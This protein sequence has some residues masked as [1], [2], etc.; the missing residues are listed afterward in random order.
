MAKDIY[1]PN[2]VSD[3]DMYIQ[4]T[5]S[6]YGISHD[7]FRKQLWSES[8]FKADAKSPTGPLG[9]AQFTEATGKAYGLLTPEDRMDPFKSIDAAGRHV[10]DLVQQYGGDELKAMLAYNQGSGK[11]GKPQLDAYDNGDYSK[12]STEGLKYMMTLKDV[13]KSDRKEAL[14]AFGGLTPKSNPTEAESLF[15]S[16]SEAKSSVELGDFAQASGLSLV[17]KEVAQAN[18]DYTKDYYNWHGET[19]EQVR[20]RSTFFKTEESILRESRNSVLGLAYRAGI[21]D[22]AWSVFTDSFVPTR[23]NTRDFTPDEIDKIRREVKS[24]DYVSY[25][26]GGDFDNLDERIRQ[27]NE[28]YENDLK[29][30]GA[31]IGAQILGGV[32][33]A[34]MDPLTFVPFAGQAAKGGKLVNKALSIG[35]QS[36]GLN[37]LS[38]GIRTNIVGGEAH[39]AEAAVG[40]ALFG[41]G[42]SILSDTI[43]RALSKP[44]GPEVGTNGFAGPS[45]RL[46]AR[47]TARNTDGFDTSRSPLQE[48]EELLETP[49]GVRYAD[50]KTEEGA[51]KLEDGSILS[52]GNP[53]N[54][55]TQAEFKDIDPQRAAPGVRLGGLTEIGL[56]LNRSTDK[57]VLALSND[58]VRSPTGFESGSNGKFGPTAS[59]ISERLHNTD[60]RVYNQLY[61]AVKEAFKDPEW[62][63]GGQKTSRD[64]IRQEIYKRAALAI[65][66]PKLVKKLTEAE[67]RVMQIMKNQFDVKRQMMENPSMFGDSRATGFFPGSRHI[68]TYVP[69]VYSTEAKKMWIQTLG[70]SDALQEAVKKSWLTSYNSRPNVKDRVNNAL[71]DELPEIE[72]KSVSPERLAKMVDEYAT[73]K[74]IGVAKSGEFDSANVLEEFLPGTSG[75]ANNSFLKARNLFD[76]DM[77]ITTPNGQQFSVNDLRE[78]DMMKIMPSYDRR[79]NGDIAIMGGT[80]KTTEDLLTEINKLEKTRGSKDPEVK[81]LQDT[82]KILTGRAR[83]DQ[84][85]VWQTGLRALQDLSF[86]SKNA[87]MG[88]Q[89]ITEIAGMLAQGNVKSFMHGIPFI[90]DMIQRGSKINAKETKELHGL[91]FGKEF[92]DLIKPTRADILQRLRESGDVTPNE[93]AVKTFGTFKY[94]TGTLARMSPWTRLLQGTSNYLL[95]VGRQGVI[96]DVV[97][98][99]L[100]GK[101]TMF[102]EARL[103]SASVTP[104][105]FEG[106]KQ[107]LRD[108]LEVGPDGK[109]SIKDRKALVSDPR[110]M[111]L[112]RLGDKVADETMLRP[113]KVSLQDAQ[114]FGAGAR[115]LLQFKSFVVKSLNSKFIRSYYES[116]KNGRV[117]DQA[118]T[119]I[120]SLGIAGTYFAAQAKVKSLGLPEEQ[121]KGYLDRALHPT[122]LGY[123]ALSRS[124]HTGAPLGIA[125]F[126]LPFVGVEDVKILRSTITPKPREEREGKPITTALGVKSPAFQGFV[127]NVLEQ[128][129]GAG[130][131]AN[132]ASTGYNLTGYMRSGSKTTDQDWMTGLYNTSKELIPN[133]ILTQQMILKIYEELGINYKG[134]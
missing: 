10:S 122:M 100:T 127:T 106:I 87:Y 56:V 74:S 13:S 86:F 14:E 85:T 7:L 99:A 84:D 12:I 92:D 120:L 32:V 117:V 70:D 112:W 54:P 40:G 93:I 94:A 27:A 58:L 78:F 88:A 64:G 6:K 73:S 20:E 52:A 76:S 116:T 31:G 48:G 102:N 3:Y 91:I 38:E 101:K 108:T 46:E 42:M 98:H 80:G 22:D 134:K 19:P 103:K 67:K 83:R 96:V 41:G 133:D 128:V 51:V 72:R 114:A 81:A 113:N 53:M 24:P 39:Y 79:V 69:N 36:A 25:V 4:E 90:Q 8:R 121:R 50:V 37:V 45:M 26:M 33:G 43:G 49:N 97:D 63:V 131:A 17:G 105:Q 129:P 62:N 118:L 115:L 77:E 2:E 60:N 95:D 89:N 124:S 44:T 75:L 130:F 11:L 107:L 34:G 110:T 104:E 15:G 119:H 82:V 35:A 28:S 65:E 111:D 21:R 123:A 132:V 1:N 126:F 23:W 30:S 68:D 5:A 29:A 18:I 16:L 61:D 71:L 125:N 66:D 55:K 59:D 57:G 109:Y 9:I 47:E